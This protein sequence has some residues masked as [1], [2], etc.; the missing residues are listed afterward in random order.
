MKHIPLD[1]D[2]PLVL[3]TTID[4][5]LELIEEDKYRIKI[6]VM[7]YN[8]SDIPAEG[9]LVLF[10]RLGLDIRPFPPLTIH[11]TTSG[12]RKVLVCSAQ[13]GS[14]LGPR[15]HI[16]VCTL[17]ASYNR[18]SGEISFTSNDCLNADKDLADFTILCATGASNF[19]LRQAQIIVKSSDLRAVIRSF[20]EGANEGLEAFQESDVVVADQCVDQS[21]ADV[22]SC[23]L[24]EKQQ[25]AQSHSTS[26]RFELRQ[27]LECLPEAIVVMDSMDN[28]VLWNDS[29]VRMFPEIADI[30]KPGVSYESVLRHSIRNGHYC[31]E[32]DP[33]KEKKLLRRW[34]SQHTH[35]ET[36]TD[37]KFRDGRWIRY[38]QHKT[39]DGKKICVRTDVTDDKIKA[40][41][42]RMLF[43]NNPVPMWVVDKSSQ[44]YVDVNV[45]A[46]AHYGYTRE[47]FLNMTLI[48]LRPDR[49]RDRILKDAKANFGVD[50]GKEDWTHLKADGSEIIVTTYA[51]PISY[52]NREA[53]LVAAIDV[54]DRRKAE[55][56]IQYLA[57][58]D[59]LTGLPN[60]RL[61]LE[62][63]EGAFP[64]NRKNTYFTA[65][66]LVDIDNFKDVNDT[67]GHQTG[68]ALI[69]SVGNRI[70]EIVGD[71]GV[72]ARLG[73]DEFGILL[74]ML[75]VLEDA[76]DVCN[77]LQAGFT[78]PMILSEREILVGVSAGLSFSIDNLI[79]ASNL[80]MNA[81]L[82]LYRAKS[83]GRGVCRTYEPQMSLKL[84][85]HTAMEQDLK[86]ALIKK[87][88]EIHYQP[89]MDLENNIEVGFEALLRWKHPQ[90][91]IIPPATFIPIAET[92]GSMVAIGQWVLEQSCLFGS[93]LS[94]D[95]KIAVNVSPVQ[96]K[97]GNLK[98]AVVQ[99]LEKSG[100]PPDR[101]E[102]E[103]TETSLLEESAEVRETL[104]K[105][106]ALG[107]SLV[108]DDFG[109]GYSGLRYLSNFPIDKIKIDR[110][111]IRNLGIEP[112]ADALVRATINLGQSLGLNSP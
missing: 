81:D 42:F 85:M 112:Q 92:M 3:R 88:F 100:L 107:V 96:L 58:H 87:Q 17:L 45:A 13:D 91:G 55:A 25:V 2:A 110:S 49:E 108:L 9:T 70:E 43:E 12:P 66:V 31:E 69:V 37:V 20:F 10:P 101:L 99:A 34:L 54:T 7:L 84:L 51:K 29:Y 56:R 23:Q 50:F 89:L 15:Q 39:P 47:A 36:A 76:H 80:L 98:G 22:A 105:L 11:P 103:I 93:R 77:E 57:D 52:E 41:S 1:I 102:L 78:R 90:K 32:I 6:Y 64:I 21:I 86:S 109:T 4:P 79:S 63:L 97:T 8:L 111:F 16:E 68:D 5:V 48:D 59:S 74:P 65:I 71:R 53:A 83:D 75:P 26:E 44:R 72:V 40:A 27:V 28:I 82:A 14:Q 60:R 62:L 61:F 73:G 18:Q 35:Y 30:L 33:R 38:Q 106:K 95:L 67:L 104:Q 19:P 46:L 94:P 24:S